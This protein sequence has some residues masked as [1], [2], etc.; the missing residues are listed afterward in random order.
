MPLGTITGII[1]LLIAA[2]LTWYVAVGLLPWEYVGWD[3]EL[4]PL[5]DVAKISGSKFLHIFLFVGTLFSAI[6]SAN[7]C[8]NDAARAWFSMG[9]DRYLPVWFAAVHPKY[10]TPFRSIIF[11]IPIGIIFAIKVP[12]AQIITFSILSGLLN[13]TFMPINMWKFRKQWP[14][15]SIKRGYDASVPPAAGDRAAGAVHRDLLRGLSRLWPPAAGDDGASISWRRSGS[16]SS[17]T[18]MCAAA[19]S[20]PCPGRGRADY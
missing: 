2:A 7:G 11:L 16:S 6:A 1:T 18:S 3:L 8:I 9:R 14:L 4:A 20:S 12:L 13:Y 10:R 19:I 15:G 5:Y 17:A